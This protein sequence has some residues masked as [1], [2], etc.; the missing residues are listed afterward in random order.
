MYA[1]RSYYANGIQ[2]NVPVDGSG[3]GFEGGVTGDIEDVLNKKIS[4]TV[5]GVT[6][7]IG[8]WSYDSSGVKNDFTKSSIVVSQLNSEI[9]KQFGTQ[10][11]QFSY[12]D[13]ITS[14]S[15]HYTKLYEPRPN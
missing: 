15:I 14:Y 7:E 3:F 4:V 1:I 9:S 10:A 13:V 8:F 11:P 6:K 5:N 12:D 2:G